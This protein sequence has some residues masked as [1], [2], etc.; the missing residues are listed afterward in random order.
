ML[1]D[2][3][4]ITYQEETVAECLPEV[5]ACLKDHYHEIAQLQEKIPLDPDYDLYFKAELLGMLCIVTM[6]IDGE[7]AGYHITFIRPHGHYKTTLCGY[8]DIYYV[9]PEYRR[10]RLALDMFLKAEEILKERG[11]VWV[12]AGTKLWKD[13]A[14]IFKRQKWVEAERLFTKWI[15]D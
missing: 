10:G 14:S 11:V 9:K 5:E 7:L 3:P 13:M 8:V 15:G 12:F 1:P 6:R 4:S 2:G